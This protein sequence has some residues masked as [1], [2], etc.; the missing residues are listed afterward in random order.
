MIETSNEGNI[1]PG[2]YIVKDYTSNS[3]TVEVMNEEELNRRYVKIDNKGTDNP[4]DTGAMFDIDIVT[5]E[6]ML[7]HYFD[8]YSESKVKLDTFREEIERY[9][10]IVDNIRLY[11]YENVDLFIK[12]IKGM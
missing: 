11:G 2:N 1:V 4:I 10:K 12:K 8:L 7:G 5:L 6:K 9:S 3:D